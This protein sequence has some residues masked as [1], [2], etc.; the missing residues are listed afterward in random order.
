MKKIYIVRKYVV[1]NS[2]KEAIKKEKTI[3]PE[4]VYLEDTSQRMFMETIME[5]KKK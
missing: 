4:D 3:T 5:S 1:A 2:V